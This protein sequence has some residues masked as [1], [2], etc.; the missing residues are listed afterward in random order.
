MR[1]VKTF[2][3]CIRIQLSMPFIFDCRSIQNKRF[4]TSTMMKRR[5]YVMRRHHYEHKAKLERKTHNLSKNKSVPVARYI[6]NI[7][8][9]ATKHLDKTVNDAMTQS[10]FRAGYINLKTNQMPTQ[11]LMNLSAFR[12]VWWI[13][14]RMKSFRD[15]WIDSI[16]K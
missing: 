7:D 16:V 12:Y 2:P 5:E 10:L 11:L 3:I 9:D 15:L 8:S 1:C 6:L 4:Q 13:K 14:W